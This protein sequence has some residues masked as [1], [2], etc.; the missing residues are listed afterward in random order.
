M[1]S[2]GHTRGGVWAVRRGVRIVKGGRR[3]VI[4]AWGR[5]QRGERAPSHWV[6][7]VEGGARRRPRRGA[8]AAAAPLGDAPTG[9]RARRRRAARECM[10]GPRPAAP[11]GGRPGKAPSARGAGA[12]R[13]VWNGEGGARSIH[14]AHRRASRLR[15][16]RQGVASGQPEARRGGGCGG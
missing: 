16:G 4:G 2:K 12:Q 7:Q 10:R 14:R 8:P 9:A 1:H 11:D 6:Y 13:L 5:A 3:K 15:E